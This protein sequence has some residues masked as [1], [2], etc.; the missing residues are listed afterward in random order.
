MTL[1]MYEASIPVL[2]RGLANLAAV[3]KKGLAFAEERKIDPAVLIAARLAPDMRPLSSQIQIASDAAKGAAARLAGVAVPSFADT[4]TTFAE[5]EERIA[6]TRAFLKTVGPAQ[7]DGSEQRSI[8]LKFGPREVTFTGQD[9]LFGFVL[10]NF[11][12]HVTT[13]Y[14]ILRH[15]GAP[16]GKMDYLGG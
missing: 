4:E 15:N 8:A 6:K 3:L 10:P 7:I 16:L 14:D 2:D 13:A 12:F 1:S 5:L 9:Y 11:Y